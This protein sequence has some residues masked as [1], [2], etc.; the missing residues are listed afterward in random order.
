M[1]SPAST[2]TAAADSSRSWRSLTPL[3]LP[4]SSPWAWVA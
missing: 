1:Q 2:T 3:M 4:N